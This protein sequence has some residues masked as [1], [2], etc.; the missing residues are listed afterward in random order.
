MI[1][2]LEMLLG[3][4]VLGIAILAIPSIGIYVLAKSTAP[5]KGVQLPSIVEKDP[6]EKK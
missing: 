2:D 6:T 3:L 4:L 1:H 5:S